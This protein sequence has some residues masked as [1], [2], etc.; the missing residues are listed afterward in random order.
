MNLDPKHWAPIS[1]PEAVALMQGLAI[2][3]WIAGGWALDLFLGR[4]TRAH[5]DT[6]ILILRRDQ[7]ALHPH[8]RDWVLFKTQQPA[9]PHLAPWPA[10]EFLEARINDLWVRDRLEDGPWRFEFMLMDA[11]G[12]EWI[13]RRLPS[14]RGPLAEI[15]LLTPDGI[16]YLAPEIQLL[17]KSGSLREKDTADL[18]RVLPHLPASRTHG[19]SRPCANSTRRVTLATAGGG[20]ACGA[21][22]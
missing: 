11:E 5:E 9:W 10:G 21:S 12:E 17:Y 2:P 7:L 6:D 1:I 3:W 22:A 18:L 13:Y 16:P 15:G 19:C 4:T 20:K 8:L 14:I